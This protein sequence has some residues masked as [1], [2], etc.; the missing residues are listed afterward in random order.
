MR[1][2]VTGATGVVGRR[3]V[4]LLVAAGH[5]VTAVARSAEKAAA[6]EKAGARAVQVDL[7][8]A[9]A[10]RRAV[11]GH[12]AVINL[13]TAVPPSSRMMLPGAWREMDRIRRDA[14]AI[15]VD[16][17]LAGGVR[18]FV[19]ESFAP[20]YAN[21]GDGWIDET[22]P[23]KPAGYNRTTL[24]AERSAD[25]FTRGG[26]TGVALRFAYFYG[27][28]AGGAT[29]D[30][31]GFVRK[32]WS[33]AP[34]P[35]GF[36]SSISHDDAATAV[37][38]ALGIPAGIYN[39]VDDEPLRRR[40]FFGSMARALGVAPPRFLPKWAGRLMGGAGETLARSLRISNRR[41]REASGWAPKYP[42]ARD[43]WPDLLREAGITPSA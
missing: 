38:A 23:V 6:V 43:A 42:G 32:G 18:R 8:D 9:D 26:G 2:F 4:P 33:P 37:V 31:I 24:D 12:E 20:I 1:I 5:E 19:Q 15:L 36:I 28:D 11:D 13:A 3:A 14:S 25:R 16:A 21:S 39:V 7:F 34:G 29:L 40:E 10:V 27:P 41:F 17:A 22:A 30:M 35:E